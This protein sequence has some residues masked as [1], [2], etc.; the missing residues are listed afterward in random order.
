MFPA[1]SGQFRWCKNYCIVS[2]PA[3]PPRT[4]LEI[5]HIRARRWLWRVYCI[6]LWK[7]LEM[8]MRA[9]D[10]KKQTSTNDKMKTELVSGVSWSRNFSVVKGKNEKLDWLLVWFK[11]DEMQANQRIQIFLDEHILSFNPKQVPELSYWRRSSQ[12][13]SSE[14]NIPKICRRHTVKPTFHIQV[15]L[16]TLH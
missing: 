9:T 10:F 11:D 5:E 14:L 15:L 13:N 4:L 8:P 16:I 7:I 6:C 3:T 1:G 2:R 12:R